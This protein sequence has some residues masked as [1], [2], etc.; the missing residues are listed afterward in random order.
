MEEGSF[1]PGVYFCGFSL[2]KLVWSS[3]KYSK[4]L[5]LIFNATIVCVE[6]YWRSVSVSNCDNSFCN[7]KKVICLFIL[8]YWIDF[9]TSAVKFYDFI[10]DLGVETKKEFDIE[11]FFLPVCT[12]HQWWLKHFIIQQIH[13]Y[14][15]KLQGTKTLSN[16]SKYAAIT[17]TTSMPADTIQPFL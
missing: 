7:R 5:L 16:Y 12:M 1:I 6:L 3:N 14:T 9:V 11:I 4:S 15:H 2:V 8:Q 17:P 10:L 13:K